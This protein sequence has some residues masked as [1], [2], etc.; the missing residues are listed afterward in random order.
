MREKIAEKR[1]GALY[2]KL[3]LRL[4]KDSKIQNPMKKGVDFVNSTKFKNDLV[5]VT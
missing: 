5:K 1:K 4:G 2:V 3:R